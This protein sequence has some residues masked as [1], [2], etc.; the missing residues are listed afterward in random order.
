VKYA[1]LLNIGLFQLTWFACVVGGVLWGLAGL[2]LMLGFS[3]RAGVLKGDLLVAG[4]AALCGFA[5]DTAWI[6]LGILDYPGALIAPA[7]IV[8]LWIGVGLSVNHSLASFKSRPVLGGVLAA[9]SAPWCYLVGESFGAVSVPQPALLA[10]VA[11]AWF[12]VFC[13]GFARLEVLS[14]VPVELKT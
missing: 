13:W 1:A 7:W 5:L 4:T 3:V 14:P 12:V 2:C 9:C 6:Y 10:V 11:A 8:M